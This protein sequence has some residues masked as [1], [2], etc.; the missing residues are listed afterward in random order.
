M[1]VEDGQKVKDIARTAE[2]T[3]RKIKDANCLPNYNVS[4]DDTL[5]GPAMGAAGDA[6]VATTETTESSEIVVATETEQETDTTE[7]EVAAESTDA[8]ETEAAVEAVETEESCPVP[9]GWVQMTVEDGQK[10]KDVAKIA[11]TTPRKI[12]DA[13]CLPNYNVSA[14]DTLWV[15]QWEPQADD[16]VAT[17]ETTESTEIVEATET[18]QETDSTETE[19]VAESTDASETEATV[20]T[21]EAE[22]SCPVP[23]GWVQMTVEQGQKVK[24]VARIARTTPRKIKDANCLPNYNVSAGDTLWVPEW[25]PQADDEQTVTEDAESTE[26]TDTTKAEAPTASAEA[27]ETEQATADEPKSCPVPDGWVQMT[28][29]KGQKVRD[30]ARIAG[31]TPRKIKDA[32]CLPNYNVSAGDTLWVPEWGPQA[33]DDEA[34]TEEAESTDSSAASETTATSEIVAVAVLTENDEI[35]SVPDDWVQMTV[36]EGQQLSDIARITGTTSRQIMDVNCLPDNTVFADEVLWVPQWE[37]QAADEDAATE[38]TQSTATAVAAPETDEADAT[39][40]V[41]DGWQQAT[42]EEDMT[43]RDIAEILGS[44]ARVIK[45]G[46]CLPNYSVTPGQVIWVPIS[47]NPLEK[48]AETAVEDIVNC[49]YPENWVQVSV[50]KDQKLRDIAHAIGVQPW[51]I[52]TAN[53][54]PDT[55]VQAGMILWVPRWDGKG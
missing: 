12:K 19:V 1:T 18:E 31:T 34:T 28:V 27:T 39:C 49:P 38:S 9:D 45:E 35:C 2:T 54:L 10:V 16:E 24:D 53:C 6:E 50:L 13:N 26:S 47:L 21:V 30:I 46:N 23:D 44:K 41:P 29:E 7:T 32:N 4:A 42:I 51:E 17:T 55:K 25:E 11:K 22:E 3:P 43:L 33:D 14:D 52:K 15:P 5:L 37:E 20:E 36:E 8:S 40:P 48:D